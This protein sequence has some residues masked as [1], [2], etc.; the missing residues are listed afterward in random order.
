[1]YNLT[2][3]LLTSETDMPAQ[4]ESAAAATDAVHGLP[5]LGLWIVALVVSVLVAGY[6]WRAAAR[7]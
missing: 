5:L 7:R 1:M 3:E 2:A 4:Y 6:M